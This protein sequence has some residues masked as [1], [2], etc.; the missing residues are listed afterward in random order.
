MG[1]GCAAELAEGAAGGASVG[2]AATDGGGTLLAAGPLGV[3][4]LEIA[5][6]DV[7]RAA[8]AAGIGL[9]AE[10]AGL[11]SGAGDGPSHAARMAA[12]AAASQA[13][14]IARAEW[15]SGAVR[16]PCAAGPGRM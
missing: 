13:A 10:A 5:K 14:V 1:A 12:S 3:A 15:R 2:T 8:A 6:T 11:A 9:A 4:L 7:A 16:R